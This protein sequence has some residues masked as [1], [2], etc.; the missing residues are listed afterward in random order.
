MEIRSRA[1][2][3]TRNR[4]C[5]TNSRLGRD[6]LTRYTSLTHP[7]TE[8]ATADIRSH[9]WTTHTATCARPTVR[10][11][12]RSRVR[13]LNGCVRARWRAAHAPPKSPSP[14]LAP[15]APLHAVRGAHSS[16]PP[17][18]SPAA[19]AQ[20]APLLSRGGG[21]CS[22]R[23]THAPSPQGEATQRSAHAPSPQGEATRRTAAGASD[24]A[25]SGSPSR[26]MT[27]L[28]VR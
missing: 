6:Q 13:A 25:Y 14:A 11:R 18:R 2:R 26:T 21:S 24:A 5:T 10:P 28:W 8:H 7:P 1:S 17:L 16:H 9:V 23:G 20:R 12:A 3:R 22:Q 15:A 19:A 27:S 4:S